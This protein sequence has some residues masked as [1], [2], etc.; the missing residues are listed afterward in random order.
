MWN[1]ADEPGGAFQGATVLAA[2]W[3][4]VLM[5]GLGEAPRIRARWL[6]VATVAGPATFLAVGFAG[7]G[8]AGAFLAYPESHAKALILF[9]ELPMMLTISLVLALLVA[10]PPERTSEP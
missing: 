8:L 2:M 4:L 6:R 7:V 1:G 9:V 5:A 3:L 10:G